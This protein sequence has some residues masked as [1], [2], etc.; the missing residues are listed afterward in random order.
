MWCRNQHRPSPGDL[1][2]GYADHLT[3]PTSVD[4]GSDGKTHAAKPSRLDISEG[5]QWS[6][7]FE[8]MINKKTTRR[9]E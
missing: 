3:H 2:R 4:Q 9:E 5:T 8:D 6:P 7:V 1:S